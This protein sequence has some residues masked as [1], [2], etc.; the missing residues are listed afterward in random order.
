MVLTTAAGP[1][2]DPYP[3]PAPVAPLVLGVQARYDAV[4]ADIAKA[5]ETAKRVRDSGMRHTLEAFAG[6][7]FLSF[8]ARGTGRAVEVLGDLEH[9]DRVAVVVPGADSDLGN[10]DSRK[11]AG[12]AARSLAAQMRSVDP[13]AHV[14]VIAWL[15]YDSPSTLGFDILSDGTAK[16]GARGLRRLVADVRSVNPTA[17]MTLLCH[18]YGSVVCT[19]ALKGTDVQA[20]ALFGSPG[21]DGPE[22]VRALGTSAHVWAGR[23]TDDWVQL[24]PHARLF[25][26]GF[27]TD[28]VSD[29]F[30]AD[31]FDAGSAQHSDY[32]KPGTR[33]L[34]NLSRIA[35]G[36]DSEVSR[37]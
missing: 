4:R 16:D 35:L 18:S 36:R 1:S 19:N 21:T 12:G 6:R 30:G 37:A 15:G 20:V 7:Q 28:P 34:L 14:A 11:W 9:A 8:D 23:G 31:V 32:L 27:G 3:A 2:A 13:G 22:T 33:S 29:G 24:V 17:R 10:F 26:I 25:G 5:L